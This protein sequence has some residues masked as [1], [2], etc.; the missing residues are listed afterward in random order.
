M[1]AGLGDVKMAGINVANQINLVYFVLIDSLC[2]AGGI[3]ISQYNGAK[4]SAGM[5]QAYRFKMLLCL[6]VAAIY[7]ALCEFIPE[8]LLGIMLQGNNAKEAVQETGVLYTRIVSITWIPIA[9]SCVIGSALRETGEVKTPLY[10]AVVATCVNT[11]FNWV[12]I[13]GNL[14][15]PRLEV[16]GAAIATI[17]ARSVEL[18]IYLVYA[19]IRK[20][21]FYAK[22]STLLQV[23]L[24]FFWMI[25]AK[26]FLLLVAQLSWILTETVMS[27]VY[28]GR[29]GADVV[30][31]MSASWAIANLF[32][33]GING[34]SMATGVVI[35]GTL[36]KGELEEAKKQAVWM[37][38]GALVL[39]VF[40]G[41]L[42]C[43]STFLVPLVFGNLSESAHQ[44]ACRMILVIAFYF[45]FW[46][47]LNAQF[48]IARA[49][50]DTAM[51]AKVDVSVNL[52]VF[53]PGI[54]SL[55]KYTNWGPVPMFAVL[56]LTDFLKILLA[57]WQLKKEY[58]VK[59]LTAELSRA[60]E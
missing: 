26:S 51:A 32:F 57:S 50:G 18:F 5:K 43:A 36:G 53:L 14:G 13:Y 44:I 3:F 17:I 25:L 29:G 23:K 34:V 47:L 2:L 55:A 33:L 8:S 60:K 35:G 38:N 30:A 24:K 10:I 48:S 54:L 1:V 9:I 4:D 21:A 41:G 31:G 15:A 39:G 49:G 12:L 19:Y 56:K 7:F 40:I 22:W 6:L 20:P 58:W 11:F 27:A 16:A 42:A 37:Q 45:P 46:T 28:N 59:N 52:L